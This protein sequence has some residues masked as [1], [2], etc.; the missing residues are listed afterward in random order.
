M[1]LEEKRV[2]FLLRHGA[3]RRA[4]LEDMVKESQR[5]LPARQEGAIFHPKGDRQT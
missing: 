4:Y 5:S 2:I 3:F 1:L